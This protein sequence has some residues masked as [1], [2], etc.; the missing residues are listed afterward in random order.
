MLRVF[1][2]T[3]GPQ[4]SPSSPGR[5][6]IREA[7]QVD[8]SGPRRIERKR[9]PISSLSSQPRARARAQ[10]A[11]IPSLQR[12]QKSIRPTEWVCDLNRRNNPR[13]WWA[14]AIEPAADRGDAI[15]GLV[16]QVAYLGSQA[17]R[18]NRSDSAAGECDGP[19]RQCGDSMI[20]SSLTGGQLATTGLERDGRPLSTRFPTHVMRPSLARRRQMRA[21]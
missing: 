8:G 13:S 10:L 16:A 5:F 17:G 20:A 15:V 18:V 3:A 9:R 6:S 19:G 21:I 14:T 7:S 4:R 2:G 1:V 11:A 12:P